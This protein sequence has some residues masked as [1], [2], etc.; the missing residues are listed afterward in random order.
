MI[1]EQALPGEVVGGMIPEPI[2]R[3]T[4]EAI[5]L[6]SNDDQNLE[7]I[8]NFLSGNGIPFTET[9][10]GIFGLMGGT[11]N[12]IQIRYVGSAATKIGYKRFGYTGVPADYCYQIT[13]AQEKLGIRVIWWKDYELEPRF[14]ASSTRKRNVVQSYILAA[15][16]KVGTKIYA[17]ET[18]VREISNR[19][20]RP[21]LEANSFYGYRSASLT[22]GLFNKKQ[23][24]ELAPGTLIM[25]LSLG[26]PYYGKDLYDLE[27]LRSSTLL[28]V[29]VLGGAS[30]LMKHIFAEDTVTISGKGLKWNSCVFYVDLC[31]NNGNSLDKLGFKFWKDSGGGLMNIDLVKGETFNRRPAQHK[32]IMAMMAEGRVVASPLCGVRNYIFCRNGDY[33]KYGIA[34]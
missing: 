27:V 1:E 4:P 29:Q 20:A 7:Y 14:G 22:Y 5:L 17:R 10:P 28:N 24:G 12:Q 16:G 18:E 2:L 19:E 26:H 21:F 3:P 9:E 34:G 13:I 30:K 23:V 25:V 8:R 31:H 33:S 11:G 15:V 6:T 32:E